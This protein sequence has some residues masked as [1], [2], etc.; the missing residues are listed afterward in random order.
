M[1]VAQRDNRF[2]KGRIVILQWLII[3]SIIILA[4]GF[5]R[6]QIFQSEYYSGLAEKNHLKSIPV[7][8]PRGRILDRYN[9]VLVDNSPSYTI[10]TQ[11]EFLKN[12][13]E[14][15]VPIANGLGL[16][17]AQ[18]VRQI[19]T[20]R[21][22]APYR[23][24][25]IQE[26]VSHQN[27]AFVESHRIEF[28]ELDLVSVQS[29]SYLPNNFGA[30]LFGYVGEISDSDLDNAELALTETGALVGKSGIERQY[31]DVLRGEDGERRV[32]VNSRG[33]EKGVLDEKPPVAGHSL[34]LTIDYDLQEIAEES[35]QG[36]NGALV[37]LDP[38]SGEILAMVSRPAFDPNLFAKGISRHDWSALIND[39]GNPLLNRAVQAQ[40]APGSV[41]KILMATAGLESG[42]VN[43]STMFY[44]SGGGT[45]YGR[46][47]KCWDKRGHG[48][49]DIHRAIVQSC[50]VFFYSLGR[51]MGIDTIAKYSTL[52]GLGQRT[53]IDLPVEETGTMPSSA[54]KEKQFHEKWYAGETI[55]L[56]IGQ[57]A[58]TVTPLQVA[59]SVGGVTSGGNFAKPHLVSW[60]NLKSMGR[61]IPEPIVKQV[62]LSDETI[63]IVTDGMYGVV[64]EGGTGGR[65]RIIGVDVAGKTGS[66]QVASMALA[67]GS[68][69]AFKDNAW[70]IGIAP[71]RNPEIAV[72]VL[73]VG[74]EHGALAAPIAREVIKAYYDKKNG[75]QPKFAGKPEPGEN[76]EPMPEIADVRRPPNP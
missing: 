6:L 30:N 56:A 61:P 54:W 75:I 29:R 71:R 51:D 31:D 67:K 64:N 24:V 17:A 7:P 46:Y 45:F 74:G 68:K 42:T 22:R 38:R 34:H 60:K 40:L 27:I 13:E 37:A 10:M 21:K 49:V 35:F 58:L 32:I 3:V 44:C 52:F 50:D 12:L 53:G 16:D 65:A 20:S 28:P 62:P 47:F 36:D 57:G 18:L 8:A 26:N 55:S 72:A 48:G 23:P 14:H 4:V 5:F 66:S 76:P 2:A 70:F 19:Q 63:K 25:L 11:W 1:T 33:A 43:A 73:Y 41:Y 39:P 69:G 59:Y 9:R 15:A